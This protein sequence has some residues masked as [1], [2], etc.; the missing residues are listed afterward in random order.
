MKCGQ[1]AKDFYTSGD[2]NDYSGGSKVGT[3]VYVHSNCKHVVSSYDKAQK[4]DCHHSSNHSYVAEGF[5]F[6]G[7]VCNDVGNHAEAREDK[8][9]YF[10]VAEESEQM[11]IEDWVSTSSWVKEGGV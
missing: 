2:G 7:V 11:L 6:T 9:V 4:A 3:C 1:S 5:F 8:N 10:W